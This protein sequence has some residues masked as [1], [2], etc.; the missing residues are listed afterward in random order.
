MP[1]HR[2]APRAT[3]ALA[4]R[5]RVAAFFAALCGWA[6]GCTPLRE[7]SSYSD[8][9]STT[10]AGSNASSVGGS[11]SSAPAPPDGELGGAP[12]APDA[13]APGDARDGGRSVVDAGGSSACDAPGELPGN[14]GECYLL[15]TGAASWGASSAA[16]AEWGGALVTIDSPEEEGLLSQNTLIDTWIGLNDRETEGEMRWDSGDAVG[17]FTDWAPQQPDDFDGTEDCVELLADGRGY[18]D[19]PCTDLRAYLCER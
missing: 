4:H 18:N 5:L 12:T 7:L 10:G 3:A 15:V 6:G 13:S 9:P 1:S 11:S 19:R 14:E 2:V 8:G 17:P 16:C